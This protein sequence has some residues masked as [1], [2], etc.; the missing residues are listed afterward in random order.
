MS[1]FLLATLNIHDRDGYAEYEQGFMAV[2]QQYEGIMLCVDEQPHVLEGEWPYTRTV[3]IRFPDTEHAMAWYESE[4]YQQLM[5]FRTAA[6]VGNVVRL[7]GFD[8]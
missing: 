2:F 7:Q 3:L 8:A 1:C 6:S 4:A 5:K